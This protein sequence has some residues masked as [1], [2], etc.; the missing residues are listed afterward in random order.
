MS[1]ARGGEAASGAPT[2]PC[3]IVQFR[4]SEVTADATVISSDHEHRAVG[5]QGPRVFT[6]PGEKA[7]SGAPSSVRRIIQF[8]ARETTAA[9][10]AE[11]SDDEHL[12]ARQQGRSLV[13]AHGADTA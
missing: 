4:A 5:Q 9:A 6:A 2:P 8:R 12:T 7:A 11:S 1:V 3:R 10:V 13:N